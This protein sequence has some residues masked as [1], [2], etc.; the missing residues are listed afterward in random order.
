MRLHLPIGDPSADQKVAR[1]PHRFSGRTSK[2][3]NWTI[4]EPQPVDDTQTPLSFSME[5]DQNPPPAPLVPRFWWPG[6]NSNEAINKFQIE[7]GGPLHGGNPGKRLIEPLSPPGGIRPP[8]KIPGGITSKVE[9]PEDCIP[10][11]EIRTPQS[12]EAWVAS[13]AV[14]IRLRGA[15]QPLP[16]DCGADP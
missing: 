13:P 6:W 11:S 3:A 5:G 2:D 8:G 7:V 15:F 9:R 4:R 10:Q 14:H 12:D 16:S 1:E